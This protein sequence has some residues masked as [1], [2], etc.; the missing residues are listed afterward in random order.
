MPDRPANRCMRFIIFTSRSSD[1]SR[2]MPD[3]L[4]RSV[5]CLMHHGP[6]RF[7]I[8]QPPEAG[9]CRDFQTMRI[10]NRPPH[11]PP[12]VW[13]G[14]QQRSGIPLVTALS[15]PSRQAPA[16]ASPP[17]GVFDPWGEP[18]LELLLPALFAGRSSAALRFSSE[19]RDRFSEGRRDRRVGPCPPECVR[20]STG[21]PVQPVRYVCP[22]SSIAVLEQFDISN[23]KPAIET[24]FF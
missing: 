18:F 8:L 20:A 3:R 14:T 21:N 4:V 9:G 2:I 6:S 13:E 23:L 22:V 5:H 17:F 7:P 19:A 1:G 12:Q 15:W 16:R 24:T 10:E 11:R